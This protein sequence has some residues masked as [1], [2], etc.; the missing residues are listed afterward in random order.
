MKKNSNLIIINNATGV[1]IGDKIKY[2]GTFFLRLKGLLGCKS[3]NPGEGLLLHP[4]SAVH[5]FGMK[6]PID[7]LFLDQ[8]LC[9]IKIVPRMKPGLTAR[10]KGASY[11]LELMAGAVEELGIKEGEK[12][13]VAA[14]S[15]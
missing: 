13:T 4:C 14:A 7:V 5:S 9:V 12:L 3:L 1:V 2:A 8:N 15:S 6:L 11:V 10:Q